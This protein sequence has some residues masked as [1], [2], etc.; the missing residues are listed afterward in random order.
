MKRPSLLSQIV[1][2]NLLMVTAGILVAIVAGGFDFSIENQRWQFLVLAMALLLTFLL[3]TLLLRRRFEPFE[4]LLAMMERV[5]LSRPGRRLELDPE[6]AGVSTDIERLAAT[7]NRMLER[8]EKERRQSGERVLRAQEEERKRVAR[9]LHDEVNQSLTALL[10]RIEA[11]GQDAPPELRAELAQVKQLADQAMGELL[12]LARQLRPTALDDHGLVAALTT[13]VREFDRRGQARASFWAD[14]RL[15]GLP[16]EAQVVV[17]RV[18]Q[19][20]LVNAARHS[21]A[22]RVEVSL[23][24]RDSKVRLEVSDNGSGFAFDEEGKGLG[25]S[26]MRER[27]LLVGGTLEIEL[28]PRQGDV[29]GARDTGPVVQRRRSGRDTGGGVVKILIADDHGIVRSGVKLLLDRQPDMEVIA[30]AEDGVDA[31]EQTVRLKP[32]VAVLDV[33]MPRMTGLQATHEIKQQSPAT[34][35]LIL[36]MHDDERYLFEALRAGASGYVL[37]RAADKDLVEA[38]RAASRGEPFLT[39][40]AQQAL[41]RDFVDRGDQPAELSPREQEVVKL[42]AEAHTNKEIAEIL[43]LSE[44]TVESHR[45]RVLQK[46]GMRDRVELVRYAIRR[47]LVEP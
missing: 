1:A 12:D 46:L 45:G 10:L 16:P 41:I 27:A 18:A 47:G 7:F 33:S 24:P 42:I 25:L 11:A 20:A 21:G 43:H 36:S 29:G 35:V 2:L 38:V 8:L 22:D 3:N 31:L 39:S 26:G 28:A 17:Y 5:D 23:E 15:G 40:A 37:K 14:P 4:R 19:E 30:E 32:D 34:Q 9:D 13:H 44:K 6:M